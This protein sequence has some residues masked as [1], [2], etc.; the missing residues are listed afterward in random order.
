MEQIHSNLTTFVLHLNEEDEGVRK[1]CENLLKDI[2]ELFESKSLQAFLSKSFANM[3]IFQY[4]E[5]LADFSKTV[6]SLFYRF[7]TLS[8]IC[9]YFDKNSEFPDKVSF[10]IMNC[11][12]QFKNQ[13]VKIR[14]NAVLLAGNLIA[15]LE[16]AKQELLSK[17][18]ICNGN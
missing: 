17:E 10:Y 9:R 14:C 6:V 13:S 4:D 18:H 12:Q 2:G 11:I 8:K 3:R 1:A 5:F 15:S 16:V 7:I